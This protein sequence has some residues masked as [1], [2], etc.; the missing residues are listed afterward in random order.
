MAALLA[1][2]INNFT[3]FTYFCQLF[4]RQQRNL[5]M[6]LYEFSQLSYI[7][8]TLTLGVTLAVIGNEKTHSTYWLKQTKRIVA[9][10]LIMAAI[11]TAV[12]FAFKMS[13]T[14]RTVDIAL[15]ITMLYLITFLLSMAFMPLA[16]KSYMTPMRRIITTLAFLLCVTLAWLS[17]WL[18]ELLSQIVLVASMA[19]FLV[20]LARIILALI[21]NYRTMGKQE[22]APGSNDD[23]RFNCLKLVVHNIIL[24]SI[25]A[26]LHIILLSSAE[27]YLAIYNFAMLAVWAYLIV[28]I[29]NLIINYNI[30]YNS[31]LELSDK[32]NILLTPH[33]EL[34]QK[35]NN[36]IDSGAYC[37]PGITMIQMAQLL[38]TNRTYLSQYINTRYGCSFN[39]WLT[40][41]RLTEAKRLLASSPTLPIDSI[42]KMTGFAS[43]SH[44]IN[45]FKASE[46]ITPGKWREN[47]TGKR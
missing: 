19:I 8:E 42:A 22:H 14:H 28:Q 15:T 37:Q 31:D 47:N 17:L 45:S 1:I 27:Q 25:F 13:S 43:K 40:Q 6:T 30:L 38:S 3:V 24:L 32:N 21:Y 10:T 5:S 41:L 29:I 2:F 12:K 20:E 11:F 34:A 39:T 36:W 9:A 16:P 7:V 23:E 18:N 35:V 4:N 26:M 33:A 46:R 44:F